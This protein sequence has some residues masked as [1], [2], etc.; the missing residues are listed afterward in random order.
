M[1]HSKFWQA[2]FALA[3]ILIGILSIGFW[4]YFVVNLITNIETAEASGGEVEASMILGNIAWFV[5]VIMLIILISLSSLVFYIVHAVQNPNLK[6]NSLLVVWI[7][8]F[9]FVSG[10]GQLIYWLVEIVGK[11]NDPKVE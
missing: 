5:I 11:R 6:G 1:L 2:F 4:M 8:L 7:L 10:I 9:V 3:P